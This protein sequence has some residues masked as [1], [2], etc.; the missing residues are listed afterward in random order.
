MSRLVIYK[1]LMSGTEIAYWSFSIHAI[2]SLAEG[3]GNFSHP[4]PVLRSLLKIKCFCGRLYIYMF[5]NSSIH[6][7]VL[8]VVIYKFVSRSNNIRR[9]VIVVVV[10]KF[11]SLPQG[12]TISLLWLFKNLFA[13]RSSNAHGHIFVLVPYKYVSLPQELTV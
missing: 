3:A 11:M 6:R 10:Y 8:V 5:R 9:C 7:H 1:M 4:T 12:V 13:S 2:Y